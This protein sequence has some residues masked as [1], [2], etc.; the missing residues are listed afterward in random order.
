MSTPI[1]NRAFHDSSNP[2]LSAFSAD[3]PYVPANKS[4]ANRSHF[5]P[6]LEAMTD[7][8]ANLVVHDPPVYEA[9]NRSHHCNIVL[10]VHGFLGSEGS[11][12]SFP[13]DLAN[14]LYRHGF[15]S[16]V[17]PQFNCNHK[18]DAATLGVCN[19]LRLLA[20][21][22]GS[23]EAVAAAVHDANIIHDPEHVREHFPFPTADP[24]SVERAREMQLQPTTKVRV[25]LVAHS[26]GGLVVSDAV[27]VLMDKTHPH[28]IPG[29]DEAIV[30]LGVI[31]L[32][33]P[34]FSLSLDV[35]M[36]L[37]GPA[38]TAISTVNS[39]SGLLSM[40]ALAK[41]TAAVST[42]AGTIFWIRYR[43][44]LKPLLFGSTETLLERLCF[45][46]DAGVPFRCFYPQI[47]NEDGTKQRFISFPE[48]VPA[49]VLE[50]FASI[51][52][53]KATPIQAHTH[54]FDCEVNGDAYESLLQ[55]VVDE[56][57][58]WHLEAW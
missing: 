31:A 35:L 22:H 38:S 45:V 41:M 1:A 30:P 54:I 55:N 2:N 32:D 50:H 42:A 7:S 49:K 53:K 12:N 5:L 27:R 13:E 17:F 25:A 9:R 40:A 8:L 15:D 19:Y 10:Y 57:E 20:L 33:T 52:T 23:N 47:R 43:D 58:T 56:I 6:E 37:G 29:L 11:F 51:E 24:S 39:V 26:M 18:L 34:F 4:Y 44:F 48:D 14:K 21:G 16:H 46:M 28:H 36:S 3:M